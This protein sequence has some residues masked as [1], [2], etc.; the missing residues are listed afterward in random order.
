M[1]VLV[2]HLNVNSKVIQKQ[3]DK[4]K[5]RREEAALL[6]FKWLCGIR[7]CVF[8]AQSTAGLVNHQGPKHGPQ[9][10]ILFTSRFCS[11]QFHSQGL[12]NDEKAC[13]QV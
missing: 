5:K 8:I 6:G 13:W 1:N 4:R 3:K 2:E 9:A 12:R 11:S 10:S 7:G